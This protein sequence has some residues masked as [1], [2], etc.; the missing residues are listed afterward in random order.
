M[1]SC[2][3]E[4]T[5]TS[6]TDR[7]L[8]NLENMN[9]NVRPRDLGATAKE[10]EKYTRITRAHAAAEKERLQI[11]CSLDKLDGKLGMDTYEQLQRLG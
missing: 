2:R 5:E 10:S 8:I 6:I 7:K 4:L 9:P 3:C 11:S 1:Y